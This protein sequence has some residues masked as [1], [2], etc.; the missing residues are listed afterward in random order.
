MPPAQPRFADIAGQRLPLGGINGYVGVRG[1][2]G[3][4]KDMFQGI[5]PR[6]QHRT[7]LFKEPT[8]AASA[9]AQL[10]EDIEV[11][12]Q[13]Q[14]QLRRP[15]APAAAAASKKFEVGTYLGYLRRPPLPV[16]PM[17]ACVLLAPQQAAAAQARGVPFAY[18]DVGL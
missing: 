10:R 17:Q 1:K 3:R 2:Q 9:L 11:G 7:K 5:T 14:Q 12:M 8:D 18:A 16:V 6:K 13:P 15:A 4:G